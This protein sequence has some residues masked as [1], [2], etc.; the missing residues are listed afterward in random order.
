MHLETAMG[1]CELSIPT[2]QYSLCSLHLVIFTLLSTSQN[3]PDFNAPS[4][5][6]EVVQINMLVPG[7]HHLW[8]S[9]STIT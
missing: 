5:K 4:L 1:Q 9:L 2:L 6:Q 8:Q 7:I 3:I